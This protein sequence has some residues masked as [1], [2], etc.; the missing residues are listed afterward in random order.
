MAEP[1]SDDDD[2]ETEHMKVMQAREM[3]EYKDSNRRGD[4]NRFGKG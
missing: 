4:G 1:N 3:D 2:E